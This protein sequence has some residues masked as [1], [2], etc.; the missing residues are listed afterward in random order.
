[1]GFD[2]FPKKAVTNPAE[3]GAEPAQ[4]EQVHAVLA[5]RVQEIADDSGEAGE[6]GI[7]Q[8]DLRDT[9]NKL[10]VQPREEE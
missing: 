10:G 6:L 9:L 3:L 7:N 2:S 5:Q 4:I 1:M 8:E